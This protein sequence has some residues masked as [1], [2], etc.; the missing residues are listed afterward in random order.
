MWSRDASDVRRRV[1]DR[2]RWCLHKVR[3]K[4]ALADLRFNY[5]LY[6]YTRIIIPLGV[7]ID[8]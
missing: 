2:D 7:T 1:V 3:R 5:R 6:K 4:V 8:E